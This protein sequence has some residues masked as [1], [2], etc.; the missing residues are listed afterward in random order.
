M[1]RNRSRSKSPIAVRRS[2]PANRMVVPGMRP[3]FG[4]NMKLNTVTAA[5]GERLRAEYMARS[6]SVGPIS[7]MAQIPQ[8]PMD[9]KMVKKLYYSRGRANAEFGDSAEVEIGADAPRFMKPKAK[10]VRPMI[11]SNHFTMN[12]PRHL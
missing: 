12:G 11:F 5:Q 8:G 9:P 6:R 2:E 7:Q 1:Q 3:G 4:P 10:A